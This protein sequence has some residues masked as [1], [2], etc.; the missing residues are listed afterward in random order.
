[1]NDKD[2]QDHTVQENDDTDSIDLNSLLTAG[3]TSSGSFDINS[4]VIGSTIDKFAQALPIPAILVDRR[5]NVILAN[6]ACARI[7]VHYGTILDKPFSDLFPDESSARKA[8]AAIEV[9]FTDRKPKSLEGLLQIEEGKIWGRMTFRSLRMMEN[10]FVFVLIEDLSPEKKQLIV[11]KKINEQLKQ[12]I[13][14]R[15][16]VERELAE[17]ERKYRQVIENAR[18]IIYM[19]DKRGFF[20]FINNVALRITGYSKEEIVGKHY[21]EFIPSDYSEEVEKFYKDQF[22]EKSVTTYFEFPCLKKSG[23]VVWLG[24][25]V[26]PLIE[27]GTVSGF[28]VIARDITDR[29]IAEEALRESEERYKELFENAYDLIYTH[30]VDGAFT[31][32][33]EASCRILGYT[34]AEFLTLNFRE[35]VEPSHIAITE[36]N[37]RKKVENGIEITGP[38]ETL[39]RTKD[40]RLRWLEVTS[41]IILKHGK[42]VGVHGIARDI[43]DRKNAQDSL[44]ESERFLSSVFECIQD[45][46]SVLDKSLNIIRVNPTIELMFPHGVPFAG[47][48]CHEVYQVSCKTCESCPCLETIET[49]RSSHA[50]VPKRGPGGQKEGWLNVYSFPL[51]VEATGEL[52]GVIEY[53][54]DI[55][56]QRRMEEQLRQAAKMEAIGT[57]AGGLAH[58]FNNLLQIV[59]GYADLLLLGKDK[60]GQD[61]QRVDA[62]RAAA[63]RGSNLVQRILTFSR[64]VETRLRPVNLNSEL[65]QVEYLLT[66]TIPKMVQIELRLADDLHHINADPTQIE[67]ILLNLAVNANHAMPEGGKLSVETRNVILDE[68]YCSTCLETRPGDYVLLIVSDTGHGMESN[69]LDRIFEPFF[70]TKQQGAGT[71]LGLSMVFGIVK[72][73]GGHIT[74]YSEPGKGTSFHIYFPAI[75]TQPH[76]DAETTTIMPAFGNETLLLVDDEEPIRNL[77]QELLSEVGYNV[78]TASTAHEALEIYSRDTERISLIILDLVMPDMGGRQCLDELLAINPKAKVVVASGYSGDRTARDVLQGGAKEFVGKPYNFKEILRAVRTTLDSD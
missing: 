6:Q 22:N 39:L 29:K 55:T 78:I 26:Q 21:L 16:H 47:K 25:N 23:G 34:P 12:E 56:E 36:E 53:I 69:V 28:Q 31:S 54:R 61:Y 63:K 44:R 68:E 40:G 60:A 50:I 11:N 52:S 15:E 66:S 59:L 75:A 2:F 76:F 10:R 24:Q 37:F 65:K 30:D 32:V 9:V 62:I 74:C 48:K 70:T 27:G 46:L 57:L 49:G 45:G 1:M 5:L 8:Q 14:R 35:I 19:T 64:R 20:T 67:Q 13:T 58:D 18:D 43:T 3:L 38:Y 33:N 71:G 41:R 72:S 51:I 42:P 77:G 17:S 4:D 73:H 7:S